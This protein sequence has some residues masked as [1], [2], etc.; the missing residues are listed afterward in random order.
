MDPKPLGTMNDL[1]PT[2]GLHVLKR[3]FQKKYMGEQCESLLA[4]LDEAIDHTL[5]LAP[6]R[7]RPYLVSHES[8][9]H[10]I[11]AEG[12]LE[13]A[14]HGQWVAPQCEP[15]VGCWQRIIAFQVNLPNE[16]D[17][18]WGE[19]DL[20]GVDNAGLPVV[21]ELK[22]ADA[23]DTPAALLVQG[24]AYGLVL[25]KAWSTFRAEWRN[26][27]RTELGLQPTLP[28]ALHPVSI[29]CVAP[30]AYWDEWVGDTPRAKT[31]R[32]AAWEAVCRLREALAERGLKATFARVDEVN[33]VF[34]T[35]VV[36]LPCK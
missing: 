18:H 20:L 13:R 24:A 28:T 3:E 27:L 34:A 31:V 22:Q 7:E 12:R 23:T 9:K 14:L 26:Y 29:V 30:S 1:D 35:K 16:R 2:L 19:I 25:Q 10:P 17:D 15:A 21:I 5:R 32:P 33:G 6:V 4:H 11:H 8:A 36:T